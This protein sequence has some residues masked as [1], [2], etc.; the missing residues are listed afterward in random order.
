[1]SH[2]AYVIEIVQRWLDCELNSEI[3][4]ACGGN[5]WSEGGGDGFG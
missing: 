4:I 2:F 1:M 5:V 3:S